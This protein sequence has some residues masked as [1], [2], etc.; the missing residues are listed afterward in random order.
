[1]LRLQAT[2]VAGLDYSI[3]DTNFGNSNFIL[4][5]NISLSNSINCDFWN[6]F[7]AKF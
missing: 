6:K 5:E 7:N 3:K 2:L 1:M 4:E